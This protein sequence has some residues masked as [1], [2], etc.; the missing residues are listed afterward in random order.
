MEGKFPEVALR[1]RQCPSCGARLEPTQAVLVVECPSCGNELIISAVQR[2][3]I[4]VLAAVLSWAVPALITRSLSV[5]PVMFIFFVF[6]GLPVAA[7]LV[8]TILPPKYEQRRS[9]AI[10]IFR[11]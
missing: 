11:R 1:S 9:G 4:V 5:S 7:Q 8:T 6:P 3:L 10:S 2:V